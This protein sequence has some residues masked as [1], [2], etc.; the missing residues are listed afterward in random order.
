VVAKCE[1]ILNE[2]E[3]EEIKEMTKEELEKEAEAYTDKLLEDWELYDPEALQEA[4][5]AGAEPRE[6]RIAELEKENK[7]LKTKKIPQLERK[8][9]SI[10]GA[11]SVDCKKLNA[12]T[13]QVERLKEENARLK[14]ESEENQDLAT[15]AYMQGASKYKAKLEYAKTIIED[16]LSSCFGYNS[17]T[18]NYEVKAKAEEFLKEV[19]E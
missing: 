7:E 6:K 10:R 9:A 14:K 17:K 11:H 1:E 5:V 4:Y 2:E 8:I 16:L 12:R 13:E 3:E 15:I 18:V 19:S